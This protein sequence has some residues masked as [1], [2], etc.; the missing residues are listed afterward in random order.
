[1]LYI[2]HMVHKFRIFQGIGFKAK[3][4]VMHDANGSQILYIV[5]GLLL[6]LNIYLCMI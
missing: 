3:I 6:N 2:M 1:M 4:Y 5:K